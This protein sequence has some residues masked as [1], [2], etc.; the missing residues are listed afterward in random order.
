MPLELRLSGPSGVGSYSVL[1]IRSAG[2]SDRV[3]LAAF[4]VQEAATDDLR[5]LSEQLGER[6]L[7][8]ARANRELETF[9]Y[10]V[11]H[12]LRT[13]LTVLEN[14]AHLLLGPTGEDPAVRAKALAGIRGGVRRMALLV[15]NIL[16]LSRVTRNELHRDNVDLAELAQAAFDEL[17]ERDPE[18]KVT[19]SR[20]KQAPASADV[21]LMR[22]A[23]SN[24]VGNAWKFTGSSPAAR[25][26]FGHAFKDG[27]EVYFV[28]DNGI[29][30]DMKDAGRLFRLFERL[31]AE[32][33][34]PGTGIGL[35]TV[36]RAIE[37][38]GGSIWADGK[39]GKGATFF[40]T[41]GEPSHAQPSHPGAT[42]E[43]DA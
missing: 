2:N 39:P 40:F 32:G 43:A 10:T 41:L 19:F 3:L 34:Y 22:I 1:A 37:R 18:R 35:V 16:H 23:L 14:Y 24:L 4:P 20:P 7:D 25:I 26:E 33:R 9:S 15:E 21:H 13:P 5:A 6:V 42:K 12:D 28:R 38:H 29:G 36:Q 30:F 8:L 11:S 17:K 31:E 27:H